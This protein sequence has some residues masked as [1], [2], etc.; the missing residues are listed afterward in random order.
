MEFNA[1][2]LLAKLRGGN[3]FPENS[4]LSDNNVKFQTGTSVQVG[5]IVII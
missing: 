4:S 1:Y 2:E 5:F 3:A